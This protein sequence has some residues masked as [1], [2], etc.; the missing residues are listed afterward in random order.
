MYG[1][2]AVQLS[3]MELTD[4]SMMSASRMSAAQGVDFFDKHALQR[5]GMAPV[6]HTG[7]LDDLS[8][9]AA[10]RMGPLDASYAAAS[11]MRDQ[12]G[13]RRKRRKSRG[14]KMRKSR[15]TRKTRKTRKMRGGMRELGYMST[16]APGTLLSGSQ[17][18]AAL[19]G[20]S[21]EWR[22]AQNPNSF[23]PK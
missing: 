15:K 20:M 10:A 11:G 3:P 21:P 2:A 4:T 6:G 7:M 22:L 19:S 5:G 23:T 17:A 16:D 1:G 18:S 9:R 8:L 14:R 13:G 12:S